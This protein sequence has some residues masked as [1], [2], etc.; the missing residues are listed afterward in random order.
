[1]PGKQASRAPQ[2]VLRTQSIS[3]FML[4]ELNTVVIHLPLVQRYIWMMLSLVVVR[5][6]RFQ[7]SPNH[8]FPRVLELEVQAP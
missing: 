1:M 7:P 5:P 4:L 2:Q 8:S 6:H 3:A